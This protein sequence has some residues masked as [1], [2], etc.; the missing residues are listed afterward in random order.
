LAHLSPDVLDGFKVLIKEIAETKKPY[1]SGFLLEI[2]DG[3]KYLR[4]MKEHFKEDLVKIINGEL[5]KTDSPYSDPFFA[6]V[7][8]PELVEELFCNLERF[9]NSE[10]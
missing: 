9:S 8:E 7:V 5:R 3:S 2:I 6:N 1:N 10:I 4:M